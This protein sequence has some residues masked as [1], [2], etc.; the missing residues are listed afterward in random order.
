MKKKYI[1]RLTDEERKICDDTINKLKGSRQKAHRA[2]ILRQVDADGPNW[3]DRQ[4]AEAFRCRTRTVEKIRRRCV[5]EGFPLALE[6]RQGAAAPVP[7]LLDG[8]QEACLIAMRLGPPPEGYGNWSLRLLARQV[9]ELGTVDSINQETVGRTQK[10]GITG[11]KVQY[12]VIPPEADAEFAAA[13]D[14]VLK[15][16]ARPYDPAHPVVCM[17]QQP[18]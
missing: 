13:M 16:Y 11:R 15:T 3:T 18:V 7:N 5:L 6:G 2:R 4:V 8:E 17:D 14:E 1:V 10:N 12:W 9:V